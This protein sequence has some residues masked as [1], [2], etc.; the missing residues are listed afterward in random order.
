MSSKSFYKKLESI[1]Y[2]KCNFLII[3]DSYTSLAH[4]CVLMSVHII[5]I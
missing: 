5:H 4:N 3:S 2:K 1:N